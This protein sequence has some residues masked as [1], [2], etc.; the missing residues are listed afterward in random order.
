MTKITTDDVRKLARLAR[1]R[2]S[3][4][5]I[6]KYKTEFANIL[7]YVDQLKIADTEGLEPTYQVNRLSTVLRPDQIIDYGTS[8]E[9]LLGNVPKVDSGQIK[10]KRVI[11]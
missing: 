9:S 8:Q 4:D 11:K 2:L 6:E 5:E 10:V 1:L 7:G 3:D